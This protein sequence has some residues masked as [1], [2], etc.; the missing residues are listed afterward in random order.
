MKV[1]RED[2]RFHLDGSWG[3]DSELRHI[4]A[5]LIWNVYIF[6]GND[7]DSMK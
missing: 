5:N 6:K 2:Y 1:W 4:F 7:Y 3:F